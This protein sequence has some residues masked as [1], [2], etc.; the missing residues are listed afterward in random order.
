MIPFEKKLSSN[1][2]KRYLWM[3]Y[4][5]KATASHGNRKVGNLAPWSRWAAPPWP[6]PLV[7]EATSNCRQ[8]FW[9]LSS[10]TCL[11]KRISPQERGKTREND[12]QRETPCP[13]K[14]SCLARWAQETRLR[15]FDSSPPQPA[16]LSVWDATLPFSWSGAQLTKRTATHFSCYFQKWQK[17][18]HLRC[19]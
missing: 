18:Y 5:E 10:H 9:S 13:G 17:L 8:P 15:C 4:T 11:P 14:T 16:L 7:L 2:L 1:S 19:M 3:Q 6:F 12:F